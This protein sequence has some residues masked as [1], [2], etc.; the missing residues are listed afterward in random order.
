MEKV[1]Q[2]NEWTGEGVARVDEAGEAA[3]DGAIDAELGRVAVICGVSKEYV[4]RAYLQLGGQRLEATMFRVQDSDEPE[5]VGR[6]GV[7]TVQM[8]SIELV[9]QGVYKLSYT[10]P[11]EKVSV[12]RDDV[13]RRK[14]WQTCHGP[15]LRWSGKSRR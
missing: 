3:L 11:K 9:D 12:R 8:H 1:M 7:I 14:A 2:E 13:G 6:D 15:A 10:E 5:S 4:I